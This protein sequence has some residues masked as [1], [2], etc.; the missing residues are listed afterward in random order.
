VKAW[1]C[2]STLSYQARAGGDMNLWGLLGLLSLPLIILLH[3]FRERERRHTV[4][5]LELWAWL[6]P[7]VRGTRPR[8]IPW[9]RILVLQLLAAFCLTAA[10]VNPQLPLPAPPPQAGRLIL[11]VDTSSSM[12]A[13]D[14]APSRLVEAQARAAARLV[15]LGSDD[16]AVLIAVGNPARRVSDSAQVGLGALARDLAGLR[17]AGVGHDWPGAL[18]LAAASIAPGQDNRLL[19]FTD[20]AFELPPSL[21]TALPA[22]VEWNLIGSPQPNQ[23][24]VTLAARPT[25]S[26]AQQVFAR[27]ANFGPAPAE[28]VIT[29]LADGETVDSSR[30]ALEASGTAALAWTLPPGARTVEVRLADT[31]ALPADDR[32]ALG[33]SNPPVEALLVSPTSADARTR[34]STGVANRCAPGETDRAPIERALCAVPNLQLKTLGPKS[35][36]AFEPHDLYVF[37]GWLPEAWPQGG[38]LVLDPP[39]DSA[40]LPLAEAEPITQTLMTDPLLTDV[41]FSGVTFGRALG[42]S[43][44][45]PALPFADHASRRARG[46]NWLSPVYAE[47]NNG[48]LIWRGSQGSTRAVVLSFILGESNLAKRNAFPILIANAARELLPPPL[49]ESIRPGDPVALPSEQVFLSLSLTDPQGRVQTIGANR[50]ALFDDTARTGLYV[51]EGLTRDG[52]LKTVGFGVNAGSWD[53][54]DLGRRAEPQFSVATIDAPTPLTS[55]LPLAD[56]WPVLVVAVVVLLLAEARLAWR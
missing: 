11:I 43:A 23:A 2:Q 32:A 5:S 53:E 16:S 56:L 35:Y 44:P 21:N 7:E 1:I 41:S 20:G 39:A 46:P 34:A 50:G 8:R 3:L 25:A 38:V 36:V 19:V 51:L 29:L 27:I 28:R 47:E 4:S 42:L 55:P 24:V 26:G 52:Q 30:L 37:Q 6:R 54:S 17:A 18:A 33:L 31:D 45:A 15:V 49:P 13:T 40:L 12:S 48:V 10:L 22:P 9:N 14:V